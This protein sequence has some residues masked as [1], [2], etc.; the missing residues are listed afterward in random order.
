MT[1]VKLKERIGGEPEEPCDSER[2]KVLEEAMREA[3]E[4]YLTYTDPHNRMSREE[5]LRRFFDILDRRE[6]AEAA[7]VDLSDDEPPA[8]GAAERRPA[9]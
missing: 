7:K 8:E 9:G 3:V 5:V 4:A 6:V 1:N 2:L